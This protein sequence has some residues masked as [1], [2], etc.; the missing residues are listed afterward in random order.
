MTKEE[1]KRPETWREL[2]LDV[3]ITLVKSNKIDPWDIDL[4]FLADKF[5]EEVKLIDESF[6]LEEA[7]KVILLVSKILRIKAQNLDNFISPDNSNIEKEE[8]FSQ[9]FIQEFFLDP[10]KEDDELDS[11]RTNPRLNQISS[12][13]SSI[14]KKNEEKNQKG[15]LLEDLLV[16]LEKKALDSHQN[17]ETLVTQKQ[18]RSK[19]KRVK[20]VTIFDLVSIFQDGLKS[21]QFDFRLDKQ[22]KSGSLNSETSDELDYL[23]DSEENDSKSIFEIAHEENLEQ[24]IKDLGQLVLDSL[25]IN[26]SRSIQNLK[27]ERIKELSELFLIT[28]FLSHEGKVNL[29]Q[30]DF[31]QDLKVTRIV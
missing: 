16:E 8:F 12:S 22:E 3:L 10:V 28:V 11:L 27:T 2:G 31:Y 24:K 15:D 1:F 14:L 29:T 23:F 21:N 17:P 4:A 18:D 30:E 26:E 9:D 13:F 20:K 5:L 7:A 19:A 25:K 6:Q